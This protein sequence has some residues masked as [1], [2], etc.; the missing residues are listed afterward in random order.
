MKVIHKNVLVE[1][2]DVKK[3]GSMY[4]PEEEQEKVNRGEVVHIGSEVP[5][6]VQDLL[7]AEP[8]IEYKEYY[9]GAEITI[10]KKKYIVMT[11]DSILLI[12]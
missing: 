5:K 6:E 1:V 8:K 9:D 4:V 3:P 2:Q 11:Y 10:D 7:K 12:L